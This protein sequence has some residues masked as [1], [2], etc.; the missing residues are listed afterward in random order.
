MVLPDKG[1]QYGF[2]KRYLED[3]PL[4]DWLRLEGYPEELIF[5]GMSIESWQE[6]W[7]DNP[8]EAYAI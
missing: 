4:F 8:A 7:P 6:T 3:M 1:K 5:E 2:P